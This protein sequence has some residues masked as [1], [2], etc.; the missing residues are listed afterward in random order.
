MLLNYAHESNADLIAVST[1]S[2]KGAT[3]FLFGSFAETLV[4]QSDI[5][6]LILSPKTQFAGPLSEI[7][8]PTDLG[9]TSKETLERV[10]EMAKALNV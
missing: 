5:P 1:L 8:F 6:V 10:A 3:R 2:R 4:L 7:L 9:E